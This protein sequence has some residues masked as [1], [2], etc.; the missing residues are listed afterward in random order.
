MNFDNISAQLIIDNL[1][2]GLYITD[3]KRTILYWNKA[4]EEITGYA[5]EEVTGRPC[6]DNILVHVDSHGHSLCRNKCPLAMTMEDG[7]P[8]EAEVFLHHRKGHRVPVSVRV[9][10][11]AD[12]SGEI[13]GGIE[14]FS[15]ISRFKSVEARMKEL[16]EYA[17]LDNLTRMPNRRFVDKELSTR[18]AEFER[19][20]VPFG[21]LFIDIDHFKR[22]NDTYG[23]DVGDRVLKMLAGT[24][25]A[26]SRPFDVFGRWGGEEF[27]GIIRKISPDQLEEMGNRL[28]LLV[29]DSYITVNDQPLSVTISLGATVMRPGDCLE[30]LIRRADALLY[31][32]KRAGRNRLTQ[33]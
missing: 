1:Y 14:I 5:A 13:I 2:D 3:R 29:Q 24:M 8:R 28:R 12:D 25:L 4:A 20:A 22:V 18:I 30:S 23:H 10:P 11:L 19:Y 6:S 32:S 16:E 21:V 15:D 17:F 31:E 33:G 26:N 9:T 7:R 27:I